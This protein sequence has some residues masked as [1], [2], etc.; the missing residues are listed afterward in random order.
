MNI[1]LDLTPI[2]YHRGVSRYTA[3]LTRALTQRAD[4]KVA[5]FG[6][7]LRQHFE[8]RNMIRQLGVTEFEVQNRP[9]SLMQLQWQ[10]GLNPIK[11]ILPK[12]DVFHSWDWL[13]P[14]DKDLPLVSTIHDVA[15]LK[16]PDTAHPKILRMH[17][18]S[19]KTLRQRQAQIIAVSRTT[20]N[21]IVNLLGIPK[22]QVH[23]VHE[24]LPVEFKEVSE[25][26]TEEQVVATKDRFNL[27]KPYLLFVGTREPRKNLSRLIEAWRPLAKDYELIIAGEP[28]WDDTATMKQSNLRFLGKVS[29]Q[30]LAVLYGEADLFCFPSLYEGFGLPILEAFYHGTPV[31]TSN[32]SSMPEVAGNAAEL[33]N[34]EDVSSIRAG[35]EK[36]LNEDLAAQKKRLQQMI[37]RLQMFGWE[38]VAEETVKVYQQA[39][40]EQ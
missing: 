10:L 23:V 27:T 12:I 25:N 37:I 8:L 40:N 1:G 20:K 33:V 30:D 5:G 32:V 26:L 34:P 21:D 11:K 7:S 19:W 28:G 14:P 6:Y 13:Q 22:Y 39:L 3:N 35:I 29:D 24:A 9:Q 36:V 16:Y 2:I 17:R 18:R 31:V 38:R 4:V 15:M